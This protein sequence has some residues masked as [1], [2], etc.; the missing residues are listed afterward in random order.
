MVKNTYALLIIGAVAIL[1]AVG[2]YTYNKGLEWPEEVLPSLTTPQER[3]LNRETKNMSQDISDLNE[4]DKDASLESA[5]KALS[6]IAGE[7][8]NLAPVANLDTE[9]SNELDSFSGDFA[10]ID[11]LNSD[12]SLDNLDADLSSISQ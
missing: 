12:T 1:A 11:A 9:L 10:D 5:D 8:V 2:I 3:E 6:Q 4:L 7:A